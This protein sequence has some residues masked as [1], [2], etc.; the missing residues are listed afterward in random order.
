MLNSDE[1]GEDTPGVTIPKLL[2]SHS[3]QNLSVDVNDFS[4][5]VVTPLPVLEGIWKKCSELLSEK[6]AVVKAPG[7]ND[8]ARMVKS[9]SGPRP[10][11]VVCKKGGQFACDNTCPNWR[12]LGICAHAVVAAEDNGDLMTYLTWKLRNRLISQN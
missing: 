12:S 1:S 9:Y 10:H 8:K 7:H 4:A 6:N 2:D 3:L 5:H 11:L